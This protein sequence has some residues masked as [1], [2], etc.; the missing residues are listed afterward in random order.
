M[1]ASY[2][3]TVKF[4]LSMESPEGGFSCSR[5]TPPTVEDTYFAI[6][7]LK[8]MGVHFIDKRTKNYVKSI[9]PCHICG[10]RTAYMLARICKSLNIRYMLPEIK[11][12]PATLSEAY[13][14]ALIDDMLGHIQ[15]T[16]NTIIDVI[17]SSRAPRTVSETYKKVF[18]MKR[19]G[20]SFNINYYVSYFQSAQNE[21]GGFGFFRGTT[22]FLENVY[23]SLKGLYELGSFPLDLK[24]CERFIFYCKASNGGFGRQILTVPGI[25]YTYYAVA[26]LNVIKRM[27][28]SAS[29][30]DKQLLAGDCIFWKT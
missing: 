16:K 9:E 3:K 2:D 28:R 1:K 18:L 30:M 7:A 17:N 20:I 22:S 19:C 6:M 5:L 27:K 11:T 14:R 25:E 10:T 4:I 24:A 12:K 23:Y 21:D 13:Y 15:S 26:S 8:E 29:G